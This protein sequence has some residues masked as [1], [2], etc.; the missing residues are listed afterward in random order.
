MIDQYGHANICIYPDWEGGM[1]YDQH[2]FDKQGECI[3]CGVQQREIW[4]RLMKEIKIAKK[5]RADS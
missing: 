5:R 1:I 3:V 4:L 2:I